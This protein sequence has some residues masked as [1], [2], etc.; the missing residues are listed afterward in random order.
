MFKPS[1]RGTARIAAFAV[2]VSCLVGS[3][4]AIPTVASS[5][6]APTGPSLT[7]RPENGLNF[8]D[9]LIGTES[10]SRQVELIS[11]GSQPVTLSIV[12]IQSS[13]QSGDFHITKDGCTSKT[14]P[15]NS[16]C[17]I[18]VSFHPVSTEDNRYNA[19]I[20]FPYSNISD[21]VG[22]QGSSVEP[23]VVTPTVL[24]RPDQEVG[25]TGTPVDITVRNNQQVASAV[26]VLS[27]S[28]YFDPA[29]GQFVIDN[30][31]NVAIAPESSCRISM[32]FAPRKG[33]GD[34]FEV[35]LLGVG[36]GN[37]F[38]MVISATATAPKGHHTKP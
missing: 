30:G 12:K 19:K 20:V 37:Q 18:D 22:L 38:K 13:P 29:R 11:D 17:T 25:T 6:S 32:S 15:A 1:K 24:V 21:S 26:P 14:L 33:T 7:I 34:Y 23:I 27:E 28:Q 36:P 4:L 35:Y 9:Q 5:A 31:C 2:L 3:I 16:S 8:G 10:K